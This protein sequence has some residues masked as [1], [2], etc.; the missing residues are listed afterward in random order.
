M[1][2]TEVVSQSNGH[3]LISDN[4][5]DDE[6]AL[7]DRQI[8]LWGVDAQ[9]KLRA[10]NV[11][12]FGLNG[13]GSEITKNI[14]LAGIKS[15]T[16]VDSEKVTENDAMANLFT[17]NKV[18]ENRATASH[19]NIKLLNPMVS[20][21][22]LDLNLRELLKEE[23]RSG[24]KKLLEG[25]D[26][27]VVNNFDRETVTQLNEFTRTLDKRVLFFWACCWGFYGISFTDLGKHHYITEQVSEKIIE[28]SVN[29]DKEPPQKRSKLTENKTELEEKTL[30]YPSLQA[31]LS[32]K[33]GK[34]DSGITRRTSPVFVLM[35]IML[36]FYE[37]HQRF[38]E[39]RTTD[40]SE[41]QALQ[42]KV[43][44]ERQLPD[45]INSNL[46]T[47][48]WWHSVYGELSPIASV[49]GAVVGQDIIRAVSAKDT[50]I[51]NFFVFSG[52][53]CKGFIE[54]VGR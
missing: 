19:G 17:N 45:N 46:D 44:E 37:K 26:V 7:Y 30:D 39:D 16:I 1:A 4:I 13:V 27:V 54:A 6:A 52:T 22:T 21:T 47:M 31:A 20:V 48:E 10:C 24:L 11:V 35:H 9:R 41:L 33:A 12:L 18:D 49:V 2:L 32:A 28:T 42:A 40:V 29:G 38:P 3:S 51:K 36:A 34:T 5:T 8:R 23:G 15:I 14:V 50:P 53:D 25:V 43:V